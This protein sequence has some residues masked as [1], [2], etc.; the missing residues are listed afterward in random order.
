[1]F[2]FPEMNSSILAK[3][4]R[5]VPSTEGMVTPS[6]GVR[7]TPGKEVRVTSSEQLVKR[8]WKSRVHDLSQMSRLVI[9]VIIKLNIFKISSECITVKKGYCFSRPQP[10][11]H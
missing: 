3:E 6:T 4:V 1:M 5:V 11:C 8:S 2:L 7:V 10:G 9:S